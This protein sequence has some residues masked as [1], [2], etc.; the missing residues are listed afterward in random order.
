MTALIS[1]EDIKLLCCDK[2]PS[3]F[4]A[5]GG[6]CTSMDVHIHGKAAEFFLNALC[7]VDNLLKSDGLMVVKVLVL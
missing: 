6:F 1:W 3:T 2:R 5:T 4:C 7:R